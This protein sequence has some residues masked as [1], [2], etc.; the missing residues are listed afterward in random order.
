MRALRKEAVRPPLIW[1]KW[2]SWCCV[3]SAAS[4][5]QVFRDS[6]ESLQRQHRWWSPWEVQ[7]Q[8]EEGSLGRVS[9]TQKASQD[10]AL[11]LGLRSSGRWVCL[12]L[13]V[14]GVV[15]EWEAFRNAPQEQVHLS[16]WPAM[17]NWWAPGQWDSG[18]GT[19][20][21]DSGL[22]AWAPLPSRPWEERGSDDTVGR[23][24]CSPIL[25]S[26]QLLLRPKHW[27]WTDT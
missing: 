11:A 13:L 23:R 6:A 14:E 7:S 20:D 8:T 9:R 25:H 4:R 18:G 27:K 22:K 24:T 5:V 19:G 12:L 15:C 17:F 26:I 21:S 1:S 3:G 10:L 16:V 2:G